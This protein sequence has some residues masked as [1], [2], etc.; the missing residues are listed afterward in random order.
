MTL[1]LTSLANVGQALVDVTDTYSNVAESDA[2]SATFSIVKDHVSKFA[3]NSKI[4]MSV[5]DEV[6]KVHPFIQGIHYLL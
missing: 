3:D 1:S 6:A 5:L 4:L 2:A